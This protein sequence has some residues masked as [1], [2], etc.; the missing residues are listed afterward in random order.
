V[1]PTVEN[2]LA[3]LLIGALAE[4][5]FFALLPQVASPGGGDPGFVGWVYAAFHLPYLLFR[6]LHED[7]FQY[8]Y[9]HDSMLNFL[10]Y[11]ASG[12]VMCSVTSWG[13][14]TICRGLSGRRESDTHS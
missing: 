5:G 12:W 14:I 8:P 10:G 6:W 3:A 9:N 7:V 4:L 1:K 11:L 13:I 2:V